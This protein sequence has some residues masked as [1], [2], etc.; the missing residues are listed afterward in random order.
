MNKCGH[1]LQ[2]T[3]IKY[4]G[5]KFNLMHSLSNM[6]DLSKVQVQRVKICQYVNFMLF[7]ITGYNNNSDSTKLY[8]VSTRYS[9]TTDRICFFFLLVLLM[10][11]RVGIS[12]K[13]FTVSSKS[14]YGKMRLQRVILRFESFT[15]ISISRR[16]CYARNR[17]FSDSKQAKP[18]YASLSQQ[19][20]GNKY[21]F[22]LDSNTQ[23]MSSKKVEF[24]VV[25]DTKQLQTSLQS[26]NVPSTLCNNARF[27]KVAR[28]YLPHDFPDSVTSNYLPYTLRTN[29]GT[30]F[31]SANA[32]LATQSLLY[33][34]GLGY[35]SIPL[36][37]TLNWILKDF[38]GQL[39]AMYLA[40]KISQGFDAHVRKWRF[41]SALYYEAS[42]FL[43]AITP[44]FNSQI[45]FLVLASVA[46]AGK[47]ICWLST[48]ASKAHIHKYMCKREN[49]ADITG[50]AVSQG[51]ATNL[52]GTSLG[53]V[54]SIVVTI[55]N[56]INVLPIVL[57]LSTCHIL[58]VYKSLNYIHD[59]LLNTN[60]CH[61][62]LK[63]FIGKESVELTKPDDMTKN[64]RL[65]RWKRIMRSKEDDDW[66]YSVK[67]NPRIDECI[68]TKDDIIELI[69][70]YDTMDT[71]YWIS[72]R[73]RNRKRDRINIWYKSDASN[74]DVLESM[75]AMGY[76][77]FVDDTA[78]GFDLLQNAVMFGKNHKDGW[79]SCLNDAEWN[80]DNLFIELDG[81]RIEY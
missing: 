68:Q 46:N 26:L 56:T 14:S 11:V 70:F 78:N 30:I 20:N 4:R 80:L 15:N 39:L 76:L 69:D 5:K 43:E 7:L 6:C 52:M 17:Y 58:S 2:I 41:L 25:D 74:N 63:E 29:L 10:Y 50:K 47:N 60:R 44:L 19:Y 33:A 40:S 49:L 54:I 42:I 64:E 31:G 24:N 59:P 28:H 51:I 37:A 18:I 67:V 71:R 77:Q 3:R 48:S 65:I 8:D 79:I 38:S 81:N 9:V 36:A 21:T 45:M 27:R 12:N 61:I 75:L 53:M 62:L 57:T 1:E 55:S 16:S 73:K 34:L 22:N 13:D 23:P 32:V 72:M 35:G 66:K